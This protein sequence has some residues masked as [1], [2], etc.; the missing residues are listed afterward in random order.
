MNFN[1]VT[2][3]AKIAQ[4]EN[5]NSIEA[6]ASFAATCIFWRCYI[7]KPAVFVLVSIG[8]FDIGECT[9]E[10]HGDQPPRLLQE[11]HRPRER[12]R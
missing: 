7:D 10:E 9:A 11:P 6:D 4:F 1:L 8:S 5:G 2:K 3:L 12:R